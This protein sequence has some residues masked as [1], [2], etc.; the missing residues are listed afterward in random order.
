MADLPNTVSITIDLGAVAALHHDSG[1]VAQVMSVA[2]GVAAQ[3]NANAAGRLTDRGGGGI[4][5]IE[6]T[7]AT[8]STGTFARIAPDAAHTYMWYAEFGT[9]RQPPRP[10]IRPALYRSEG[11]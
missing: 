7:V 2:D 3:A 9:S 8:D 11:N 6:A 10:F 1:V 5:S 4:G